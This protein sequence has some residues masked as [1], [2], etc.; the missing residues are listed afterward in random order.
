MLAED[1]LNIYTDGSSISKPRRGGV[2][3]RFIFINSSGDEA[4][5]DF[6]MSG[7]KGAN[8]IE[9]ELSACIQAL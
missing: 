8:S 1:A 6:P 9:M 5:E 2:G 3:I 7:T 4:V